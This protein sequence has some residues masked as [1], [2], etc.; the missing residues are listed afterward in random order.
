MYYRINY[1]LNPKEI[2]NV[3][4]Q[5]ETAEY[6]VPIDHP[7]FLGNSRFFLKKV[8]IDLVIPAQPILK[9][10]AKKTDLIWGTVY[11]AVGRFL[12]S[13]KLKTILEKEDNK[14]LQFIKTSIYHKNEKFM[15]YWFTNPFVFNNI[16]INFKKSRIEI[17]GIGGVKLREILVE[18]FD[19]YI[20]LSNSLAMP[21][22]LVIRQ[23]VLN[24][25]IK[26][27]LILLSDGPGG[28][29]YYVSEKLKTEILEAGCTGIE[30]EPVEQG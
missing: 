1:S 6:P 3:S 26:E 23:V 16:L 10:G 12:I 8:D 9:R 18:D 29:G 25:G 21:E 28:I 24:V 30:F 22:R 14:G 4:Y 2:G 20:F 15:G 5:F 19:K 7:N 11:G 13:Y 17:D 27:N